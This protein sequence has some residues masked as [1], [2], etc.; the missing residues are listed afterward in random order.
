[1][2]KIMIIL[3]VFILLNASL[4]AFGLDMEYQNFNLLEEKKEKGVLNIEINQSIPI[5]ENFGTEFII[6][7]NPI[8]LDD[9]EVILDK[10]FQFTGSISYKDILFYFKKDIK[11]YLKI[12]GIQKKYSQYKKMGIEFLLPYNHYSYENNSIYLNKNKAVIFII[13]DQFFKNNENFSIFIKEKLKFEEINSYVKNENYNEF[14]NSKI[15]ISIQNKIGVQSGYFNCG[16]LN[17][18]NINTPLKTKLDF[19]DSKLFVGFKF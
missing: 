14:I 2:K 11:E 5:T 9:S 8:F 16:V 18:I 12:I 10:N 15:D 1:M 19:N 7:F 6:N 13:E 4:F 3:P 17:T